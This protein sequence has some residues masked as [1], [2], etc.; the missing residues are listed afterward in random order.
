MA[1][2]KSDNNNNINIF[3]GGLF[4]LES[5]TTNVIV[6]NEKIGKGFFYY[7]I[8]NDIIVPKPIFLNNFP[9]LPR[10]GH[11]FFTYNNFLYVMSGNYQTSKNQQVKQFLTFGLFVFF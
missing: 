2:Y 1:V 7:K 10:M 8:K 11:I 6:N 3:G 5:F 9:G 4:T